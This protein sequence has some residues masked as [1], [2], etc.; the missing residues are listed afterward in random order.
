M[1]V[2]V[3]TS[4]ILGCFF[5]AGFIS[6]KE[7]SAYFSIYGVYSYIAI[8]LSCI[9]LF[10]LLQFFLNMS[11]R[12][13]N[14]S[15]FVRY[16]FGKLGGVVDVLFAICL[17]ILVGSMLAA[18]GEVSVSLGLPRIV[19]VI[20]TI[21]LSIRVVVG[22][23]KSLGRLN[24]ILVPIML[25][26]VGVVTIG[27]SVVMGHV[28]HIFVGMVSGV[29]YAF[30]NIITLGIFMLEVGGEYTA[31]QR[32]LSA[33]ISCVIICVVMLFMNNAILY[34]NLQD[35]AMPTLALAQKYGVVVSS[36]CS[37]AIWLGLFSTIT[38]LLYMLANYFHRYISSYLISVLMPLSLGA[39][40]SVFGFGVIVS[41]IYSIIGIIGVFIVIN[42]LI[43]DKK[44]TRQK[45]CIHIYD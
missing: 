27:V 24:T 44:N 42:T 16:Y 4:L 1:R 6:G 41:Y 28:D 40:I 32:F 21:L 18:S 2:F 19:L 9:V 14:F 37:V 20:I 43:I 11:V 22:N 35:V 13:K 25:V 34:Y 17:L 12:L 8:I 45:S 29:E 39:I 23:V 10:F 15:Q 31:R 38:S 3:L 33:L 5:G 30:M 26:V 7:I 36:V